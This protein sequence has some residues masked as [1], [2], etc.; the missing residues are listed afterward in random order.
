VVGDLVP[1]PR[2]QVPVQAVVASIEGPPGEPLHPG[3]GPLH[4][5]VPPAEPRQAFGLLSP[6]PLVVGVGLVVDG[7]ILDQGLGHEVGRWLEH[8]FF[9]QE[10]G[11]VLVSVR[12]VLFVLL[13]AR[14]YPNGMRDGSNAAT[15][16]HARQVLASVPGKGEHR[17]CEAAGTG[18]LAG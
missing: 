13:E 16:I 7:P 3:R 14:R 1:T 5:R 8:T 2:L 11:D 12:H 6:V 4:D 15:L 9:G 10:R 17:A 18:G